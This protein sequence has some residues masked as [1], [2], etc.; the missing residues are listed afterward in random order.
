M[1]GCQFAIVEKYQRLPPELA[2][3]APAQRV[4]TLHR[5]M[6]Q[7]KYGP[8]IA[9]FN[10]QVE[11]LQPQNPFRVESPASLRDAKTLF[12][13]HPGQVPESLW[14][15]KGSPFF[16]PVS[17][18]EPFGLSIIQRVLDSGS[19]AAAPVQRERTTPS[20]PSSGDMTAA[21]LLKGGHQ[22]RAFKWLVESL[23]NQGE[24]EY[25]VGMFVAE[26]PSPSRQEIEWFTNSLPPDIAEDIEDYGWNELVLAVDKAVLNEVRDPQVQG[27]LIRLFGTA[28]A[29]AMIDSLRRT[30]F[31]R[32]QRFIELQAA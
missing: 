8:I 3:M 9:W 24:A 23:F 15:A 20:A 31:C 16:L 27:E 25:A 10:K 28:N 26:H 17:V 19:A 22:S 11:K 12:A 29:E 5:Q 30:V 32:R 2:R 14:K 4:Y 18:F 7:Q 21:E 13:Q 1:T 6:Q